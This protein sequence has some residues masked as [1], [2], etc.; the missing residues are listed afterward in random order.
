MKI[1]E[2]GEYVIA[3]I[4]EIGS[5]SV[6]VTLE[7]YDSVLGFVH[8]SEIANCWI[9]NIKKFARPNEI[10]VAKILSIN[11]NASSINL[12]FKQVSVNILR[13]KEKEYRQKQKA[14]NLLKIIAKKNKTDKTYEELRETIL[15]KFSTLKEGFDF[16]K[17]EGVEKFCK[18][19]KINFDF[20]ND[21]YN[22]VQKNLSKKQVQIS[23]NM[24]IKIYE[25]NGLEKIKEILNINEE[26][27][28]INY[29]SAPKYRLKI[30]ASNYAECENKYKNIS[31]HIL[32]FSNK[33]K[34]FIDI[35]R[36]K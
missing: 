9:K 34:I 11:S 13:D 18:I 31:K 1:P 15:N 12:S 16:L 23:A 29:I 19:T 10:K 3:K 17:D 4:K 20:T 36:I 8:I 30:T 14:E 22:I 6:I 2:K 32:G 21:L 27:A 35:K 5:N 7:E 28:I 26:N 33:D 24:Y 25:E